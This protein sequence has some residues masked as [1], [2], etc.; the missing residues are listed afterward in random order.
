MFL[1]F[2][3]DL[4]SFLH[5]SIDCYADDSTLGATGNSIGDIGRKLSDD[6]N[7]VSDWMAGNKF[8]LNASKTHLLVMGTRKRLSKLTENVEVDMDGTRLI[9]SEEHCE[10]L[11]GVRIQSN[12]ELIGK[13]KKRLGGLANLT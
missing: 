4:P 7:S 11:L 6:C 8:K 3:N 13:L 2:F 1:V 9:E 5:E 10:T 12:L